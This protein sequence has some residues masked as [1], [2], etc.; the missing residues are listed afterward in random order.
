MST[1]QKLLIDAYRVWGIQKKIVKRVTFQMKNSNFFLIFAQ[2]ID[3]GY[4][5]E[6][7][8]TRTHDLCFRAKLKKKLYPIVIDCRLSGMSDVEILMINRFDDES[9]STQMFRIHLNFR[10]H[11]FIQ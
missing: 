8:L 10:S 9:Q 2:T 4:T 3:R 1:V 5:S 7:V 11:Y 6:M